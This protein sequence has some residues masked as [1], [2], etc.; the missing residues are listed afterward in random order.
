MVISTDCRIGIW[1]GQ[2]ILDFEEDLGELKANRV[3]KTKDRLTSICIS[4]FSKFNQNK[5]K[6]KTSV[7]KEVNSDSEND[8]E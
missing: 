6:S 2:R 8:E 5:K 7:L 1:D 4:D 3:I